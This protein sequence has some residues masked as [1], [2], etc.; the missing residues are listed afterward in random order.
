M[1][2]R[3]SPDRPAAIS[4]VAANNVDFQELCSLVMDRAIGIE[5]ASLDTVVHL[6]SYASDIYQNALWFAPAFSLIGPA[7]D[8][9]AFYLELQMRWVRMISPYANEA[10]ESS[11]Y[12]AETANPVATNTETHPT[13]EVLERSM[14]IV[15]AALET[16]ASTVTPSSA[17]QP[18]YGNRARA[19][20]A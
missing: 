3:Y 10:P 14:D 1:N 9:L 13:A 20:T 16:P 15:V 11:S 17:R 12:V 19:Q 2:P 6:N 18:Q 8:A 4:P 7:T 5:K